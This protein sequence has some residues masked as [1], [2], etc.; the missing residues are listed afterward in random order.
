MHLDAN[1]QQLKIQI[2]RLGFES[3]F[4]T[5]LRSQIC[6]QPDQFSIRF[7]MVREPDRI[8]FTLH[9]KMKNGITGYVFGFYDAVLRKG[10]FLEDSIINEVNTTDLD[11]RMGLVNWNL[12]KSIINA[13]SEMEDRIDA[14]VI[15]LKRLETTEDG[16][17][18]SVHLKLKYWSGT[19]VEELI[20]NIPGVKS[21]YEISQRFYFFD[22]QESISV[23]EAYRFLCNRWLEKEIQIKRKQKGEKVLGEEQI[24]METNSP[25]K[26]KQKLFSKN[27]QDKTVNK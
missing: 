19:P 5:E 10:I 11:K 27:R 6:F 2:Q 4:E 7:K 26:R 1:I 12:A 22:G 18:L 13:T 21:S 20:N 15:D 16:K 8:D 24:G 14:I 9:F 23:D 3:G 25:I 17:N